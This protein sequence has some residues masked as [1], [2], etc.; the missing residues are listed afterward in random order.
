MDTLE[1]GERLTQLP[2]ATEEFAQEGPRSPEEPRRVRA[3]DVA[4]AFEASQK[5]ERLTPALHRLGQL[6]KVVVTPLQGIVA[7]GQVAEA[8]R[9]IGI[10]AGQGFPHGDGTQVE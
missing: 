8:S 7:S 4:G 3:V 1:G 5:V 6:A 9:I 2:E 10:I